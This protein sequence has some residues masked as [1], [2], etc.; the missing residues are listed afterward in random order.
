[1]TPVKFVGPAYIMLIEPQPKAMQV[2]QSGKGT[3]VQTKINY[4]IVS[5]GQ[6]C[7][8]LVMANIPNRG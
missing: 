5:E 7:Q 4:T 6:T 2:V 1:M 3:N 8:K